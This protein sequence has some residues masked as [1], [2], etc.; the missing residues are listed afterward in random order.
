[1]SGNNWIT[2]IL[3]FIAVMIFLFAITGCTSIHTGNYCGGFPNKPHLLEIKKDGTNLIGNHKK[4]ISYVKG[5]EKF[6]KECKY[7]N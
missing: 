7:V 5:A 2:N 4:L 1:M 3:M 6:K